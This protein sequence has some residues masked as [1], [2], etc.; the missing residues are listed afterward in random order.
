MQITSLLSW[1][2]LL[3]ASGVNAAL[4]FGNYDDSFV[5]LPPKA[6]AAALKARQGQ[7]PLRA[8]AVQEKEHRSTAYI[9]AYDR[10]ART[11]VEQVLLQG[12]ARIASSSKLRSDVSFAWTKFHGGAAS[13]RESLSKRK[14]MDLME[15]AAL[16]G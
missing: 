8:Q 3:W 6:A 12:G 10:T 15:C 16:A 5:A 2:L 1:I 7:R 9:V 13:L 4:P 14:G 11:G